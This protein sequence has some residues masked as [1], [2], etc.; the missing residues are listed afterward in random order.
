MVL[1]HHARGKASR[2]KEATKNKDLV[3]LMISVGGVMFLF[4]LTWLFAILTFSAEGLREAFQ[5]LFTIFNSFQG[6]FIFL[7]FCAINKEAR[8]SW[9][10]MF[11]SGR[12]SDLLHSP[13]GNSNGRSREG[14]HSNAVRAQRSAT[15]TSTVRHHDHL[16]MVS[17]LGNSRKESWDSVNSGYKPDALQDVKIVATEDIDATL[18]RVME[19]NDKF[20][21]NDH[22]IITAD[23][24]SIKGEQKHNFVDNFSLTSATIESGIDQSD[25]TSVGECD[26]VSKDGSPPPLPPDFSLT[27]ATI[28][29]GIDQSDS[30]S[31]GE[32]DPV[33]KDGSPPPPPSDATELDIAVDQ[34]NSISANV[35]RK[36]S[37]TLKVSIKRYPSRIGREYDVEEIKVE[38]HSESSSSESSDEDI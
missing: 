21:P 25:S 35:E 28:E 10:E 26:P 33:P 19:V 15:D 36:D 6:F 4:G 3:Q 32:C 16:M 8:E 37:A 7:F 20:K 18:K 1:I 12:Q 23:P 38:F 27:S 11:G 13:Y 9:K 22:D 29:S 14:S 30:T 2:K 24:I 34:I 17:K 5:I 31:I